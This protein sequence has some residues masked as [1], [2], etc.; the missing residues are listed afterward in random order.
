MTKLLQKLITYYGRSASA[1]SSVTSFNWISGMAALLSLE[2]F[3]IRLLLA[4]SDRLLL[5]FSVTQGTGHRLRHVRP[6]DISRT[7]ETNVRAASPM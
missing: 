2:E 5:W 1:P 7:N 3:S 6:I 4:A